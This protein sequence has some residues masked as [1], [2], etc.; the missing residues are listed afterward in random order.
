MAD[1]SAAE[2]EKREAFLK[3]VY[4]FM[5]KRGYDKLQITG[6]EHSIYLISFT[7]DSNHAHSTPRTQR[8]LS[9][10]PL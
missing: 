4:E 9:L 2:D 5:E 3:G 7:Q 1:S 6:P 8:N 10:H